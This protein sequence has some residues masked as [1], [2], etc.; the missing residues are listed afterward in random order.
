MDAHAYIADNGLA[1][2]FKDGQFTV[3]DFSTQGQG[4]TLDAALAA[5]MG[6]LVDAS[7]SRDDLLAA[8][9]AS[10]GADV[11]VAQA[12]NEKTPLPVKVVPTPVAVEDVKP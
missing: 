9:A 8:Y 11:A 1:Y 12:V 4:D 7:H 5:Y 3:F 6:G 10:D 2:T